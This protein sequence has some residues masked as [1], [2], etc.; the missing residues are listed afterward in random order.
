MIFLIFKKLFKEIRCMI[1]HKIAPS[2]LSG[3]FGCITN[4]VELINSSS[5]DWI[6]LDVMDGNFVPNI[7]FGFPIIEAVKNLS[8]K[9]L[10]VHLMIERPER[11]IER[12]RDSGA[13]HITVHYEA[14]IHLNR[15]LEQIKKTGA[16]AGVAINPHTSVILLEDILEMVDLI[17][18]MSV[19]PGFGGQKFI[20]QTIS[21][22]KVLKEMTIHRNLNPFIEVD[23]GVGL[24]NAEVL[25]DAGANVLVAGSSVFGDPN[26]LEIIQR[27]KDIGTGLWE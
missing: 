9:P 22:I 26:P 19:N 15:V 16:L 7:S 23:G 3:D 24:T 1:G 21:K 4:S 17:C 27:M 5:A 12:F 11:Y 25:L 10:D 14:C 8:S 13:D 20:Y 18:V 2:L 6:H